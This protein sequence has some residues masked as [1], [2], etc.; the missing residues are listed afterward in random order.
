MNFPPFDFAAMNEA[1]VR[2]EIV[3][4][5]LRHLGYRSTTVNNIIHEHNLSYRKLQLGRKNP[6]KDPPLRGRAD[7]ICVAGGQVRWTSEAKPPSEELDLDSREQAWTYANHPQV[8]AVYFVLTNGRR[9]ELYQTNRGAD[10]APVFSC[11]YEDLPARLLS[12]E[13]LLKPSSVLRDNKAQE[14]DTLPALAEGLRSSARVASGW[15][16]IEALEPHI[17]QFLGMTYTIT[18]G[19]VKR[20]VDGTIHAELH[21]Q[22]PFEKLQSLNKEIGVDQLHMVSTANTLSTDESSPTTFS[23]C[24]QVTIP[25]GSVIQDIVRWRDWTLPV[26]LSFRYV[27]IAT[28]TLKGDVFSG[29]FEG[30][31]TSEVPL[32]I[33]VVMLGKFELRLA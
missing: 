13:N 1:A 6:A 19:M 11:T 9:F 5:L 15:M 33:V 8:R 23:S 2:E 30:Y 4:P 10:S 24:V 3:A 28:G 16:S 17:Q 31:M 20:A 12:I 27:S 21:T 18:D 14:L 7:Y 22:V 26:G 25:A 32:P 29:S